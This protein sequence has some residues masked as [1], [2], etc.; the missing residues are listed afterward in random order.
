MA[1]RSEQVKQFTEQSS[2]RTLPTHPRKMTRQE[3]EFLI[4][5]NL[6]ELMELLVT[7]LDGQENVI[8]VMHTLIDKAEV[9]T[10]QAEGKDDVEIMAEQADALVD[11]DY[12]NLNGAAK[13]GFNEDDVFAEVQRANMN[14]KSPIDGQFHRNND[15]KV[16]KPEGW[17]EPDIKAVI[18]R[19]QQQGSWSKS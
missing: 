6:G 5:M 13:V 17:R 12:Y 2:G 4:R 19:W 3:V 7:V 8:Q 9:P 14:K 11:I 1:T 15:G 18:R 10:F 16:L